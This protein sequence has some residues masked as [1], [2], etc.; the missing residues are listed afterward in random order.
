MAQIP[1]TIALRSTVE[2]VGPQ[3]SPI[4]SR[5]AQHSMDFRTCPACH[6]SVLEDDVEDCPFCGASMSGKPSAKPKA[7]AP[8]AQ[9]QR[10]AA[11]A[12]AKPGA[13]A[14]PA[15]A[16]TVAAG[17]KAAAAAPAAEE[18]DPFDVD[19]RALLQAIPVSPK[20]AKGKMVRVVCPM[21]ETPG[22]IGPQH[23]GKNI[24]CCNPE[25]LVPVF[26]APKPE[27]PR[28]EAAP[29]Q[30]R[31][32]ST[33]M[34][35]AGSIVLV[36]GVSAVVYFVFLK[37]RGKKP[38]ALR[39]I[40][41]TSNN[42][43]ET[44]KPESTGATTPTPP[45]A[46]PPVPLD[47]VRATSLVQIVTRAQ[48]R[49]NNRSKPYARG[50]AAESFVDV[51]KLGD[52]RQQVEAL[53]KVPGYM[54]FYEIEPLVA[55]ALAEH[56]S[57]NDAAARAALDAALA[58]ADFPVVGRGPLDAAG[59]LAA[60]LAIMGRTEEG[61]QVVLSAR[62]TGARG[63]LSTLWRTAVDT[64]SLDLE[65]AARRPYLQSMPDSQWV[66]V[67]TAVFA[68]GDAQA[69]LAWAR[70][71]RE[72]ETRDNSLAAWAGQ[73]ILHAPGP[74]DAPAL[75]QVEQV[76][77]ELP[78]AGRARVWAAVADAQ[79]ERGQRGAAEASLQNATAALA[80]IQPPPATLTMPDMKTIHDSEGKP[81]A[82]LPDPAPWH[83]AA[84]A[85]MDVAEVQVELGNVEAAWAAVKTA[86]AATRTMTP[87]P[88]AARAVR[89]EC[90]TNDAAVKARLAQALDVEGNR[91]FLA[92][93][94]YRKQ[95][96]EIRD[97][98][99]ARF[100]L[101]TGLLHRAAAMGLL[102]EAWDEALARNGA[103]DASE[104]EP[105]LETTLPGAIAARAREADQGDVADAIT[106]QFGT[107]QIPFPA[108]DEL[109]LRFS[110]AVAEGKFEAAADVLRIY[111]QIARDDLYP[112][113]IETLRAVSRLLQAGKHADALDLVLKL[114]NPLSREDALWLIAAASVRDGRHSDLWRKRASLKL[115]ATEWCALYRGFIAGLALAPPPPTE[116]PG[117][118]QATLN[119]P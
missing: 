8:A 70:A 35:T 39:P 14:R 98:A 61:R 6:A 26:T 60:A 7:A 65:A 90:D 57:G 112:A 19:T 32:V 12:P 17:T 102:R 63:R 119:T 5:S 76:A 50:L 91:V 21:C 18:G 24:K 47:E 100:S 10:T 116:P 88:A 20:P 84:L 44:P 74:G 49:E 23:A 111:E 108:R 92:F 31:G 66:T 105:Y 99:E 71:A 30:A 89:D 64:H 36:A 86:L 109:Q 69:A 94:R 115:T 15:G 103:T 1:E 9:P 83:T 3:R 78:P 40:A 41:V 106:Q 13:A 96:T 37:D 93:N 55:I 34:L 68:Q 46:P 59:L 72:M 79:L 43:A 101:Q 67:T 85:A 11:A 107:R 114:G 56:R 2:S 110:A 95:C 25:C 97:A 81:H 113:Q 16:R 4:T 42:H 45:A 80:E 117:E 73:L 53:Q 87:S 58:K 29:E 52:A 75:K 77:G 33:T 118:T 38:D 51:G 104:R 48:Q 82:G 62:D 27:A 28:P 22:F 54:P